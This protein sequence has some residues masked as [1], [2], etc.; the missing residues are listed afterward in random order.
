MATSEPNDRALSRLVT[1]IRQAASPQAACLVAVQT[2]LASFQ[3][4]TV[5]FYRWKTE[6]EVMEVAIAG[7][8]ITSAEEKAEFA[9]AARVELV[10][11]ASMQAGLARGGEPTRSVATGQ[12]P[13]VHTFARVVTNGDRG[14]G[15]L[16]VA[17]RA[18]FPFVME[19]L[20]SV[21][22]IAH[23]IGTGF[24]RRP[25]TRP[26]VATPRTA[27]P[28]SSSS[29]ALERTITLEEVAARAQ[30][31][32]VGGGR[33][34]C[35]LLALISQ[36]AP[37]DLSVLIHGETGTGKDCVARLIHICSGRSGQYVAVNA[38]AVQANLFDAHLFGSVAGSF[39]GATRD[40]PG[41]VLTA[42]G[43]TLFL[44]ELGE[45]PQEVQAKLL[46]AIQEKEV[47]PVGGTKP[48]K[49]D[50]RLVCATN[51][52]LKQSVKD[53]AF[54]EDL[55]YRVNVAPIH[56]RPLRERPE[57]V[58]RLAVHFVRKSSK[59]DLDLEEATLPVL[60]QN[61]WKGNVRQL[62]TVINLACLLAQGGTIT[63]ADLTRA[64]A[65]NETSTAAHA[66]PQ[67]PEDNAARKKRLPEVLE[68]VKGNRR[69]AAELLGVSLRTI[70]RWLGEKPPAGV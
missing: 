38:A 16:L 31:I 58:P 1:E 57:D 37:T 39:T 36:F 64:I 15:A 70:Y 43:G 46:R 23:V 22:N 28:R 68:A 42:Q 33:A 69:Q 63:A 67:Q 7:V 6:T 41:L 56:L 11:F 13:A 66:A 26:A 52:N 5:V 19:E 20:Q 51:R 62:E 25:D 18:G 48:I 60:L 35:E 30:G 50:F 59:R 4:E 21:S 32:L 44:D 34:H 14:F 2:V 17:R 54:R 10:E 45:I 49:V 8:P 29:K 12:G 9:A 24:A 47:L 55:L 53:G 65:M 40:Q 3:V 27:M 61:S